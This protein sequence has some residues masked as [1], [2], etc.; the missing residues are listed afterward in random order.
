MTLGADPTVRY[1][2][3]KP[4]GS[5]TREDLA[6]ASPYN[7]RIHPVLPPGPIANPGRNAL[8][9]SFHPDTTH[10]YLY[11]VGKDDGSR[12]HYF[13]R[14]LNE[15]VRYKNQAARNRQRTG[16]APP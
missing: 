9:A 2:L 6:V 1:A 7:T 12:E 11:F 5:L 13:G 16:I 4:T 8:R 15:H 10:G 3:D 14:T